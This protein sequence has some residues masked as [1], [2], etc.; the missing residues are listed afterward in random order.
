MPHPRWVPYTTTIQ[1]HLDALRFHVLGLAG[2][3]RVQK[4]RATALRA[5][6]TPIAVL[7]FRRRALPHDIAPLAIWTVQHL[8]NPDA[9]YARIS[10]L[11]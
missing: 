11:R 6:T 2:V 5:G 3:G 8:G 10:L 9:P 7:A 1:G 4:K